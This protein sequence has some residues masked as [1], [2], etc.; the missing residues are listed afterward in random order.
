[1]QQQPSEP[2]AAE[3]FR[4]ELQPGEQLLW[5]GRPGRSRNVTRASGP[6]GGMLVFIAI[7]AVVGVTQG[8]H[9]GQSLANLTP[10]ALFVGLMLWNFLR[11]MRRARTP[12]RNVFYAVTDERVL[13]LVDGEERSLHAVE[14]SDIPAIEKR[15]RGNGSGSI[16]FTGIPATMPTFSTSE[17]QPSAA[18]VFLSFNDIPDVYHVYRIIE[19]HRNP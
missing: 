15:E 6:F 7:F 1:M 18:I 2:D 19:E 9:S 5:T 3:L 12:V 13:L 8:L 16:I 11:P 10:L 4:P 17:G 14:L